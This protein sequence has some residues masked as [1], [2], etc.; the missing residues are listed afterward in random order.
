MRKVTKAAFVACALLLS[1]TSYAQLQSISLQINTSSDDAEERGANANSGTGTMD[2]GSSDIELVNDGNDGDQFIGLRFA[3]VAIPPQALISNAYIQ[4]TVDEDDAAPGS[5]IFKVEDADSTSTFTSTAFD[6]SSR[7]VLNDSVVWSNIPLWPVVGVAGADQQTPDLSNL[8]QAIINR[9]G[10]KSG[11]ALN[12]IGTGTGERTAESFDGVP[13]SA[14][15]LIIEFTVPVTASFP[16]LSSND[17]AEQD[18]T[19]GTMDLTSSDLELTAD[20]SSNQII[21]TRFDAVSIPAGSTILDA[22]VQ[23]AVDEVNTNAQVDVMIAFEDAADAAGISSVANDL[24]SRNYTDSVLWTSIPAWAAVNDAGSAQRTPNLSSLVQQIVNKQ[25]WVSGNAM[26][27]G[28]IDPALMGIVGYTGNTS[29]RVARSQ[30]NGANLPPQLVVTYIP[31]ATYQNGNFPIAKASSWKYDDG[32]VDLSATNWTDLNYND[33]TWAFGDAILGYGN[34]NE[35]T[36]L[37]FG[38]NASAKHTTYYLRNT[39][40][41]ADASLYD[42]LVFDVLRDD[43]VVVYV[44]GV[45]AFRQNMPGG[46]V[47]FTTLASATVGSA[48]E[49]TYFR[50]KTANLLQ[51]GVNV[52][53]VELHQATLGSS[54]LS[55]DM[56]VGF[57]LPPLAATVF[58]LA[59]ETEWHYLDNGTSLDAVVWNDTTFDDDNWKQGQGPL[60]YGDPMNTEISFGGNSSRKFITSYFR[61][62]I[63]IDLAT[64]PDSIEIGL[65]RDDG[66]LVYI[67]GTEVFR[68]NMPAGAINSGT[69]SSTIVS[70]SAE[71]TYYTTIL[72]KN[73]FHQGRNSIAVEVHN[74]DSTSSDL[75]F[76]LYV[77]DAPIVNPPALGC[78][79]SQSHIA[80]FTSIAPT[81]QTSNLIIPSA[82]HRF[83]MLFKQGEAYTK[84]SGSVPGNHDFTAYVGLN[85]SSTIGHLSVNHENTPGGVSI[86]DLHYVDSLLLWEVDTTQ[87]VDIYNND[88]VSTT[89]NCSGGITPWGTVISAEETQNAGDANGDGYQDVGWLVEID[90]LTAKVKEYGN[91]IQ[92]KLWAFGRSSHENALIMNDSVTVYAGEDGGSS[93]VFKFVADNKT[94][95]SSGTLYALQLNNPISGGEPTGS[96]GT[97]IAIPNTTQ[98]D[99]NNKRSLAISLGATNFSGV[100]DVELSPVDGMIYFTSKG[101]GRIYRFIDNGMSVNGF[102]TF[103][104]GA[105]Y[106]LNTD[107]GVF[108]EAW[109]GG[110][111]NLTF[112]DE[113]NLWVLQDGGNDYIWVVRPDHTQAAPK[114]EL[115]ASAPIGSEPT[116]L[117]FSPDYRFGFYSI[118]HPSGSNT[119]QM[120][121]AGNSVTFDGSATIVFSRSEYLGAQMPVAGFEADVQV[122]LMGDNV[123]FTDTSK[124]FPS[125]REWEFNGG[126][127]ATSTNKTETVNYTTAGFY[128]VELRVANSV[129]SDTAEYVQ[130]IE[131]YD[132]TDLD[133]IE[134][135]NK[136]SLYPNPT[137]DQLNLELDLIGGEQVH[138]E[139]FSMTGQK[140]AD[141][142]NTKVNGGNN[143]WSFDLASYA[144]QSQVL[145]LKVSVDEKFTQRLIQFVK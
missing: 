130:Y 100:E 105:S 64:M 135:D 15:T 43:G 138:I 38:A 19:N 75:A 72:S 13:S 113:G 114:V 1:I 109:G 102:E 21:A 87:A 54:D 29:K 95:L 45:E 143:K 99:R 5:V 34:S 59:K 25:N 90:P 86:V 134:L 118:Q 56:E 119:P 107:Q 132:N 77:R 35:T 89:R 115:F 31:P 84:G 108:T 92:E 101:N 83:Q 37:D 120:D 23:F 128:T 62:D 145:I 48:D 8:I 68:S 50:T 85:G 7:P 30:D 110:N 22:Y 20:G 126:L 96:T 98:A 24:G 117:T 9:T 139:A 47:D 125:S 44:N 144:Q 10:W 103:V 67:N 142:V 11:N 121:A 14:A 6:I 94:D 3:N 49:T 73:V 12:I 18:A 79:T 69:Y 4:F 97:W 136:L 111:D 122:V 39:F 51:N 58:P 40:T 104:G 141:L 82:S 60:G 137:S 16:V 63:M 36:T 66:A 17:D 91:G 28:M 61:R 129:G 123:T 88:L 127:P 41:V 93:A 55:F 33:S 71:T 42:S 140:V 76:D 124:F 46:T 57:E 74:R 106:V 112:D 32:G 80:C 116:G 53:A 27:M 26:L 2:L 81:S 78:T 65:R 131:V 133:K 70:G 52:I